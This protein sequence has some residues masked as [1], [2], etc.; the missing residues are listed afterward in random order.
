MYSALKQ[1]ASAKAVSRRRKDAATPATS[2]FPLLALLLAGCQNPPAIVAFDYEAAIGVISVKAEGACL[3]IR[4]ETLFTGQRIQFV[5][6]SASQTTG[7]AEITG[8]ADGPSPAADHGRQRLHR[9]KIKVIRGSLEK[10][11]PA[12]AIANFSGTLTAAET[13]VTGDLDGDGKAEAFRHCTSSE[14]LHLTVW[15]GKPLTGIRRW[16]SYFYLGY[17]VYANCTEADTK[18]GKP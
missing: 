3:D 16:H 6:V 10:A 18:P 4:N 9:Y 2:F 5:T 17:D 14:G 15:T 7:V 1:L 8:K 11:A 13:G 12:F